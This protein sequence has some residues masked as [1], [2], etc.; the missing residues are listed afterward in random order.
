[1]HAEISSQHL[2]SEK[3]GPTNNLVATSLDPDYKVE[4]NGI[5]KLVGMSD[6]FVAELCQT[7]TSHGSLP[8]E[9]LLT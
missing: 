8:Q 3:S 9:A 5:E 7:L 4:E 2:A 6:A 1:M